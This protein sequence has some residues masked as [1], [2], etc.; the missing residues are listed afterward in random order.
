MKDN[1]TKSKPTDEFEES[2]STSSAHINEEKSKPFNTKSSNIPHI[3]N[4]R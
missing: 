2:Q 4:M 3:L 1:F